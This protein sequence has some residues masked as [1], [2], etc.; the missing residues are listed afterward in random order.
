[1]I[2]LQVGE[3]AAMDAM[4]MHSSPLADEQL[5]FEL[6]SEN[7]DYAVGLINTGRKEEENA[8]STSDRP[9]IPPVYAT[10]FSAVNI[11]QTLHL[12]HVCE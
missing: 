7:D 8:P 6:P 11:K 4:T 12:K 9:A 10:T 2:V 3:S 5:G 1:M